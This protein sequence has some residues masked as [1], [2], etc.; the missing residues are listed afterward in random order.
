M[1][2]TPQHTY[3]VLTKRSPR[4]RRARRQA[5]L[6]GRTSGWASRSRTQDVSPRRPPPRSAGRRAV[7]VLRAAARPARR[8]RPRPAST[9]SSPAASRGPDTGRWTRRGSADLRDQCARRRRAVLL[10]AVGRAHP[11]GRRPRA[12]RPDLGRDARAARGL[13]LRRATTRF[14]IRGPCPSD[15][16]RPSRCSNLMA[17]RTTRFAHLAIGA[18]TPDGVWSTT[19]YD[20]HPAAC[21]SRFRAIS[22]TR[23]GL[24]A[25]ER[26]RSTCVTGNSRGGSSCSMVSSSEGSTTMP[27][28]PGDAVTERPQPVLAARP[29]Q[30]V[31]QR[32]VLRRPAHR[33]RHD[34]HAAVSGQAL[35]GSG[36]HGIDGCFPR[37]PDRVGEVPLQRHQ[38]PPPP[39]WSRRRHGLLE[40][41]SRSRRGHRSAGLLEAEVQ[42][43]LGPRP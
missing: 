25:L 10:Q 38:L 6:A 33:D 2:E 1:R 23:P 13:G 16:V 27:A 5:R 22:G 14:R 19:R 20:G 28:S 39:P 12:R 34:L 30:Q 15:D 37:L 11:E 29:E 32:L 36:H 8:D 26:R 43:D 41:L 17:S 18:R 9:G 4:L 3:Q 40:A 42:Q 31:I 35:R 7:P 24:H 21:A